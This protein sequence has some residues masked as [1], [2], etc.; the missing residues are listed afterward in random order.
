MFDTIRRAEEL[1]IED[2][3]PVVFV[4]GNATA[5]EARDGY[6]IY[7]KSDNMTQYKKPIWKHVS[8]DLY[9]FYTGKVFTWETITLNAI[10][11]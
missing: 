7:K 9:L 1:A 6:G 11:F 4:S 2:H 10:I 8:R 3:P 5:R